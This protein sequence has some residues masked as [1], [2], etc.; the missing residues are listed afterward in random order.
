MGASSSKT[1]S[2]VDIVN[3][4]TT[5]IMM[6]NIM[7]CS[8]TATSNQEIGFKDLEF[9]GCDVN[10]QDISQ[11]ANMSVNLSCLQNVQNDVEMQNKL[12]NEIKEKLESETKGLTIGMSS[13]ESSSFTN[14]VN[15]ISTNVDIE[16][17]SNCV[18]TMVSNQKQNFEDLKFTCVPGQVINFKNLEQ[19]VVMNLVNECSQQ[20]KTLMKNINDLQTIADKQLSAKTTGL[21]PAASFASL[22]SLGPVLIIGITALV[23]LSSILGAVA[24]MFKDVLQAKAG[25]SGTGKF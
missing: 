12:K 3:K 5:D 22:A 16:T 10:F 17:I 4:T 1:V 23:V 18:A 25:A 20:N 9:V 24:P 6:S 21:D 8:A 11:N 13:S 19:E 7:Q 2:V 15:E 14:I